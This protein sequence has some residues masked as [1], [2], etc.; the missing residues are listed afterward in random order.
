MTNQETKK[1]TVY[2]SMTDKA[3]EIDQAI[4]R[5]KILKTQLSGV[6]EEE[7]TIELQVTLDSLMANND[8]VSQFENNEPVYDMLARAFIDDVQQ[9]WEWHQDYLKNQ[10]QK[11]RKGRGK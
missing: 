9:A 10:P 5:Y 7:R 2:E 1:V 11:L 8:I 3:V 6:P 4:M